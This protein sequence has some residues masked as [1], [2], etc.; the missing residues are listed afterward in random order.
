MSQITKITAPVTV[1][2]F[3]GL[4]FVRKFSSLFREHIC[5]GL[6]VGCGWEA[7]LMF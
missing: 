2:H 4:N 1:T 6:R 3:P 5:E 7:I